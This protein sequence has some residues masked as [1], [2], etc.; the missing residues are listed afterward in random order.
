M[1]ATFATDGPTKCSGLDVVRYAPEELYQQ[2]GPDF[3]LL[4]AVQE[5]H[6]TPS[7]V[8]QPFIYCM[9]RVGERPT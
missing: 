3:Q 4:E 7:G 1:V 6:H 9:C 2:F 8:V 5:Q